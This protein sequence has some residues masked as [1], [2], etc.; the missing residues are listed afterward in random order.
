ME[1]SKNRLLPMFWTIGF[2]FI[3]TF[4]AG[5]AIKLGQHPV[6]PLLMLIVS[7]ILYIGYEMFFAAEW[8]ETNQP[9]GDLVKPRQ[10][11]ITSRFLDFLLIF[12]IVRVYTDEQTSEKVAA[13]MLYFFLS[14]MLLARWR[15]RKYRKIW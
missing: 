10:R 14:P 5:V 8:Y 12:S 3:Q 1:Q 9:N 11:L 15:W 13:V 4:M 7:V 6:S 2:T